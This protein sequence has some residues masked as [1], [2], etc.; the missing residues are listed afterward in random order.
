MKPKSSLEWSHEPATYPIPKPDQ[1]SRCSHPVSLRSV[2]ILS[3]HLRLGLPSGRIPAGFPIKILLAL[4]LTPVCTTWPTHINLLDLITQTVFGEEYQLW[5]TSLC[6]F[7]PPPLTS[8]LVHTK[9]PQLE[10]SHS[11]PLPLLW[12]AKFHVHTKQQVKLVP[13]FLRR[14]SEDTTF[15]TDR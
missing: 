14:Q 8:S 7:L 3:S 13:F 1:S 6:D 2:L 10:H 12:E 15:W 4:L 11:M 9:S 5:I